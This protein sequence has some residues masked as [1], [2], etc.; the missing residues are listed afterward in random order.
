M[1]IQSPSALSASHRAPCDVHPID[2]Q[3]LGSMAGLVLLAVPWVSFTCW[4]CNRL[5]KDKVSAASQLTPSGHA[6]TRVIQRRRPQRD[7][8]CVRGG[9]CD[10]AQHEQQPRDLAATQ[11]AVGIRR[12][13]QLSRSP[14]SRA[15][16]GPADLAGPEQ[17]DQRS[18][19]HGAVN[20]QMHGRHAAVPLQQA[21]GVHRHVDL[22]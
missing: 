19:L 6:D 1:P 5:G 12:E 13:P 22:D 8:R 11:L 3:V 18:L 20:L 21:R 10:T 15:G 16:A 17:T 4:Y 7:L 14:R 9:L 2:S